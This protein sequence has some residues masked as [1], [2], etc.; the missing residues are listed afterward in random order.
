[1]N[2]RIITKY[3]VINLRM[4]PYFFFS[5]FSFHNN[6]TASLRVGHKPKT[7]FGLEISNLHFNTD[8]HCKQKTPLNSIS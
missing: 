3:N 8:S 1:M 7:K 2:L 6:R 5:T 4:D